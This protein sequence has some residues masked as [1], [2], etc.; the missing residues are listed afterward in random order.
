M[1][2]MKELERQVE[3]LLGELTELRR[4]NRNLAARVKKLETGQKSAG[5]SAGLERERAEI[6]RR[7]E[8]LADRLQ[9]LVG[10]DEE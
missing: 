1:D 5:G 10:E 6:K 7:V 9:A 2:S 8:R 3:K 4:K